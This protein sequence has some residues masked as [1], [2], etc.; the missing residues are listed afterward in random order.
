MAKSEPVIAEPEL[1]GGIAV[2][3]SCSFL[4]LMSDGLYK[5]LEDA[6]GTQ[7]ANVD[8]ASMVAKEFR[9]QSTL[10]GVAQ[11]VVDKIV[12]IHHDTYMTCT[13]LN[14]KELLQVRDDITLLVRNFNY[15]LPNA[16]SSPS[17]GGKG[18]TQTSLFYPPLKPQSPLSV[19]IPTGNTSSA[20]LPAHR[21]F[22]ANTAV[23]TVST[24]NTNTNTNSTND[25]TQSG[26]ETS[27]LFSQS[28]RSKRSLDVDE[29]GRVEAY[30]DFS[31]FYQAMAEMTEA[32][33]EAFNT[34]AEPKPAYETIHEEKVLVL[35]SDKNANNAYGDAD[36]V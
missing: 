19:V 27:R 5:S 36:D 6:T 4:I 1:H 8:I 35:A 2:E 23:S 24:A 32:Q 14:R 10:N 15:P 26:E 33:V 12:R 13:D 11:A 25:S 21:P 29:N 9:E 22:F 18:M 28:L 30:I 20:N 16:M 34:D 7:Q 3:D 17:P 31:E